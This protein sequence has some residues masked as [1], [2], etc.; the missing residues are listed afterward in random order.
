[1]KQQNDKVSYHIDAGGETELSARAYQESILQY[2]FGYTQNQLSA[3]GD[4]EIAQKYLELT[5]G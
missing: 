3:M 4:D 2:R 1:M 5:E